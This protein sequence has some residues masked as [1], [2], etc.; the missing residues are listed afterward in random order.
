ATLDAAGLYLDAARATPADRPA[1]RLDRTRLAAECLFIDLSE[2][3]QSDSILEAAI[4]DAP[5][6]RARAEALSLRALV[7]YY[8][9]RVPEAVALGEQAL[10]EAGVDDVELTARILGR[11][12]FLV[13]QLDL[14]VGLALFEQAAVLLEPRGDAVD[15]DLLANVLLLRANAD[16]GLVR[17]TRHDDIERGLRLITLSGRSWEREGADGSAFGLARLTDDLDRA[18][19]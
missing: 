4:R 8:H 9:G 10:G 12:A 5:P 14:E 11:V 15:P 2:M 7:R 17:S 6:G 19:E 18:I 3:V 13:R 16:L 1:Q